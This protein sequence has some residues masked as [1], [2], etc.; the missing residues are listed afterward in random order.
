MRRRAGFTLIE[1]VVVI[2]IGSILMGFALASFQNAQSAFAARGAKSM[3]ATFHQKARARAIETGETVRLI[4]DVQGDSAWML[5][6]GVANDIVNFRRELNVD[7]RASSSMF[8]ICMTPRGFADPSCPAFGY[9]LNTS[10]IRLEFW[11][12]SDS[13]SVLILPMGQ[14]VGL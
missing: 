14:L 4:V 2:L 6:P 9:S 7:L 1:L 8:L 12:T 3:Y 13:S 5:V 11:L 10:P